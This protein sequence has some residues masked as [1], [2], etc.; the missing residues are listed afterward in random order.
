MEE[1]PMTRT[2][3]DKPR[4]YD[5]SRAR[6]YSRLARLEAGEH[7]HPAVR[8]LARRLRQ[9]RAQASRLR[10]FLRIARGHTA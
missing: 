6:R 1:H 3:V 4:E 5:G 8:S 7:G 9:G 10:H 2:L